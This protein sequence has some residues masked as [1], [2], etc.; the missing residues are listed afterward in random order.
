MI[1]V[2]KKITI[3]PFQTGQVIITGARTMEQINEAYEFIKKVFRDNS[4]EIMRKVYINPTSTVPEPPPVK[5]V[6]EKKPTGWIAH[7]CPR[8]IV[9][10]DPEHAEKRL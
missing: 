8:N 10:L 2:C 4:E 6:K 1:G 7:P 3:S 9:R 5:P